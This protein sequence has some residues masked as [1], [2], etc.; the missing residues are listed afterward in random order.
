MP[1]RQVEIPFQ[2]AEFKRKL[3]HWAASHAYCVCL[4]S[5]AT[6]VDQYGQYDFLIGVAVG[7]NALLVNGLDALEDGMLA[8]SNV[9]RFGYFS[10]DLK[11]AIEP[12]LTNE[13]P[14]SISADAMQFFVADVVI[15]K[16]RDSDVVR[17]ECGYSA[18]IL[19]EIEAQAVASSEVIDFSG[20]ESNFTEVEY[21]ATISQLREH[22]RQGDCYEINLSQNFV[23][24]VGLPSPMALWE[25]LISASPVP[26]AGFGKWNALHLLC[27]SP[28]RF[29]QLRDGQLLTQPIKG[30]A[31][32]SA[33]PVQDAALAQQ[34]RSSEKE[35]AENVMIVD[36]SRNDL[37]R[38][39][40]VG[41]VAVPHL[42]EVQ[43]F[44]Q[45]HHLVSTVCGDKRQD[46]SAMQAI[47]HTFPPGSMTGAPKVR[48]CELIAQYERSARGLYAGALGYIAP[49]GDFDFNVV[50][51]SL[52]YDADSHAL[53]YHV[54]GAITW[55]SEPTSEYAETLLK[56]AAISRLFAGW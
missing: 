24:A 40:V 36:L 16:L 13:L 48:V 6:S 37:H 53:S 34:L 21:C 44:P 12:R 52:V 43:H 5:C 18:E 54:G 9:W 17:F 55:D 11:A 1:M 50:I 27:A 4:D 41:T 25:D 31:P 35:L 7:D 14:A 39:C 51:R 15:A 30:T 8:D 26:F 3:L 49:G 23:A 22:I 33:D 28:E 56:A 42:F 19:R 46:V 20:F 47:R 45:V 38:S 29:L 32:R 2:G 10:Y